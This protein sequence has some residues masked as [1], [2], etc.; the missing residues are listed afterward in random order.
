MAAADAL[1]QFVFPSNFFIL[2]VRIASRII[3]TDAQNNDISN[4]HGFLL[5]INIIISYS[6]NIE[7]MWTG[8]SVLE[9]QASVSV[10][11]SPLVA[12]S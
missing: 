11:P 6:F 8:W 1:D 2:T 5:Y 10:L 3:S 12:K 7:L 4:L 9:S